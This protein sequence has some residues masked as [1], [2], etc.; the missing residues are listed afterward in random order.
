MKKNAGQ[1]TVEYILLLL[2]VVSLGMGVYNS[3][4][5]QQFFGEDSGFFDLIKKQME[6][7]YTYGQLDITNPIPDYKG[8]HEGFFNADEN[9]SRFW[10]MDNTYG[11]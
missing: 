5:F 4:T 1:S 9:Q 7:S 6:I 2:V 10:I 11:Q 8:N 3:A